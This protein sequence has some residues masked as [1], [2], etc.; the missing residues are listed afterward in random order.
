MQGKVQLLA[1]AGTAAL[2]KC[3]QRTL[4]SYLDGTNLQCQ[5]LHTQGMLL[6]YWLTLRSFK[7]QIIFRPDLE[8]VVLAFMNGKRNGP[9]NQELQ[10]LASDYSGDHIQHVSIKHNHPLRA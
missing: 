6:R 7:L 1:P 2:V 3:A 9:L 5:N 4:V 10:D 8:I